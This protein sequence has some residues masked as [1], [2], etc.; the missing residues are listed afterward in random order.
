[1]KIE[2]TVRRSLNP[3]D[4]VIVTCDDPCAQLPN[5]NN[6]YPRKG[7]SGKIGDL[8][9]ESR[10]SRQW[11]IQWDKRTCYKS[12]YSHGDLIYEWQIEKREWDADEN[13]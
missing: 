5:F 12:N 8:F 10:G 2:T 3:G 6:M 4:L 9:G 7:W 11:I 1:M 13:E